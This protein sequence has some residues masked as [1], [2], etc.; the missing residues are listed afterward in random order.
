MAISKFIENNREIFTPVIEWVRKQTMSGMVYTHSGLFHA[1]ETAC[2]A[3]LRIF[4][5]DGEYRR[6]RELPPESEGSMAF[7]IGLGPYDHHQPEPRRRESGKFRGKAY[8]SLGL[9]VQACGILKIPG[10]ETWDSDFVAYLD[11]GDTS[12]GP[13]ADVARYITKLNPG[14]DEGLDTSDCFEDAVKYMQLTL[15]G[16]IRDRLRKYFGEKKLSNCIDDP[17]LH[18]H[19]SHG[20]LIVLPHFLPWQKAAKELGFAGIIFPSDRDP[21]CWNVVVVDHLQISEADC[22]R[23]FHDPLVGFIH[24]VK[25]MAVLANYEEAVHV[26]ER[27]QLRPNPKNIDGHSYTA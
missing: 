25:F 12:E 4:G 19:T 1:D 15:E 8:A 23:R 22:A 27:I 7:D 10:F 18:V 11:Q 14:S 24:P 9:I 17:K 21:G 5:Y 3:F 20:D 6:V 2:L 16:E 13:K 26:A